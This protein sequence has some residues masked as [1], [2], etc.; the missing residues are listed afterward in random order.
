MTS[1]CDPV[2]LRY[3]LSIA[4]LVLLLSSMP[5]L[6]DDRVSFARSFP[7]KAYDSSLPNLPVD[8]WLVSQLPKGMIAVWGDYITDCGEQ[9]GDPAV[10]RQR[11]MPL[12][13]EVELKQDGKVV[14]HFLLS[15]GSERKGVARV[16]AGFFSGYVQ[17]DKNAV[18]LK[19][20]GDVIKL[21]K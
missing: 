2:I 12:C 16:Y 7:A 11:D 17:Q 18:T 3:Y 6:A 20:L 13:A 8:Q 9:T 4:G 5:V 19:R 10:D 15:I 14:G 1:F 21:S